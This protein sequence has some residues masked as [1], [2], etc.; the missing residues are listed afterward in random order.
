MK[1]LT[2]WQPW[3][4]LMALGAKTIET[5]SWSTR[6]RGLLAIHAAK[7]FGQD[8]RRL[9]MEQPF[10]D[11]LVTG[12]IATLRDIPLGVLVAVVELV[13]VVPTEGQLIASGGDWP[14]DPELAFGDYALGRYAWKTRR[15]RR[16]DPP[17]PWRG[18]QG[19]FNLPNDLSRE[20][21]GN[22]MKRYDI[23][24]NEV[25]LDKL[26]QLEPAWAANRVRALEAECAQA[27]RELAAY[28]ARA[29]KLEA[30]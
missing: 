19:L 1:A 12:G 7:R 22:V 4:T 9:C 6:Y 13:E 23:D 18:A 15:L 10:A 16:L 27:R 28:E 30:T 14:Q 21:G 2:L 29:R 17:I 24:G 5:R 20:L 25:T 26:C 11:V 8:E 3:A